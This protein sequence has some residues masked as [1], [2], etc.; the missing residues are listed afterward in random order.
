MHSSAK[1]TVAIKLCPLL[2]LLAVLSVA[3]TMQRG[4]ICDDRM[5]LENKYGKGKF[6][7]T[8]LKRFKSIKEDFGQREL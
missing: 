6:V 2:D 8:V 7:L 3:C 4:T 5:V 1:D